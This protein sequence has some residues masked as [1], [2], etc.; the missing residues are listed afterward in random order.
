MVAR[1]GGDEFAIVQTEPRDQE[2]V[3]SLASS[4]LASV[5]GAYDVHGHRLA[6]AGSVGVALAPRDGSNADEL[7]KNADL[8]M[9]AAKSDGRGQYRFFETEMDARIKA[10][11]TLEFDLREAIMVGGFELHYQPI[12]L[13]RPTDA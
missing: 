13:F 8:A 9:Y 10:R 5:G 4:I 2:D 1:L 6:V 12:V 7:L 3:A 11:R